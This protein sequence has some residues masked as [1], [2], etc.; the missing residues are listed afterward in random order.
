MPS[1]LEFN[2][3][4][5]N[6][7]LL[8]CIQDD[9]FLSKIRNTIKEDTFKSRERIKLIQMVFEYYDE[10]K[11]A[12][13]DNFYDIFTE[14]D[15][16]M[17]D[18]LYDHCLRLIGVIKDITGSNPA[19]ILSRITDAIMH[20][21]LEEAS[22]EF[23]SLIKR[24]KYDEA[25][26]V[27]RE[28]MKPPEEFEAPYFD[29]FEDKEYILDRLKENRF[30]MV[31]RIP[32]LDK[33]IGGFNPTWLIT[34]L[35]AT[36][37]GKCLSASNTIILPDGRLKTIEEI[38]K[39]KNETNVITYNE[40][41]KKIQ[42][43]RITNYYEN[44]IKECYLVKTKTGRKIEITNNHPLLTL[45]GWKELKKLSVN[46]HIAAPKHIKFF[47]NT[48]IPEH[49]LKILA[50][51]LADG[52]LTKDFCIS[53]T[54]NESV[55]VDDFSKSVS[56]FGDSIS[57]TKKGNSYYITN[58][59]K[60]SNVKKWLKNIG[61]NN[62]KSAKKFI[63]DFIFT[64]KE[65]P[66]SLFLSTLFTCDGSINKSKNGKIEISYSTISEK[67]AYQ[68]HH[69]LLRFG[70]VSKIRGRKVKGY[71]DYTVYCIEINNKENL[72]NYLNNIGFRF[73]KDDRI[74]VFVDT[75]LNKPDNRGFFNSFPPEYSIKVKDEVNKFLYKNKQTREWHSKN[76]LKCLR[77]S[78]LRKNGLNINTV[79]SIADLIDSKVLKSDCASDIFWDKIVSIESIGKCKTY[80]IGVPETHNFIANDI[81]VHNSWFLAELAIAG[82]M[83]G[84]NVTFVS[85]EMNK[86]I[87]KER[88]DQIIGFLSSNP[89]TDNQE[90][91]EEINGEWRKTQ[92]KVNTIFDINTVEKNTARLKKV[93]GG[94]LKIVAFTRGR[95]NWM[96]IDRMLDDLEDREGY[97]TDLLIVDYLGIMKETITGQ[98]KKN[99]ITE[100]CLGLKE[101]CGKKNIIGITAMQGNRKA[102]QARVFHSHLVADDIDTIFNSDLV[103]A[104]CQTKRELER[105]RYRL[106]IAEYRHGPKGASV[107]LIRDLTVGQIALGEFDIEEFEEE[108]SEGNTA[109]EDY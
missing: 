92:G 46:D 85:L 12:P 87:A 14:H 32:G 15:E 97:F 36:K 60:E 33:L 80:D 107:G 22:V 101:I 98:E 35:G 79:Q 104:I 24:Q 90:I 83:Q 7:I 88:F 34:L 44:G 73:S 52:C 86:I 45:N 10:F 71:D 53:F 65:K 27:M 47:G 38:V 23:A 74:D 103:M 100:N 76:P 51:L 78:L 62:E 25:R 19:Y 84:L 37:A 16:A 91:M 102:M 2:N 58:N 69:L 55:I 11:C 9:N 67:M 21:Q 4:F 3:N 109:G 70:V 82:T 42:K 48:T 17:S 40:T 29:Y 50:Y 95:M 18:V 30:K 61:I 59:G 8:H 54:K 1:Q 5:L 43:G 13:K 57:P 66:L 39:D 49:K 108:Q 81:V 94:G 41:T 89:S 64:L 6:Q 96:D 20:F 106:Y 75:I 72:L 63:P 56:S 28:A 99:R 31:T 93:S 77:S 68:I 26:D 105:G